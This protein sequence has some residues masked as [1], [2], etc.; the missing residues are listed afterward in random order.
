MVDTRFGC[1]AEPYELNG[2][3]KWDS[4]AADGMP[5]RQLFRS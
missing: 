3:F 4:Q 1:F 5:D 2:Y